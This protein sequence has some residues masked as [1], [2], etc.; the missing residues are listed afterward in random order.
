MKFKLLMLLLACGIVFNSSAQN[1]IKGKVTDE[2]GDGMPGVN[3]E[4]LQT[5]VKRATT[6]YNGN[7]SI[8]VASKNATITFKFIGYISQGIVINGRNT[9]DVK[10]KIDNT[11]LQEVVVMGALGIEQSSKSVAYATQSVN[12]D[13]M[14]ENRDL[15]IVNALE[16]Q[17]AGLQLTTMGQPG[18]SSRV[19][20]R[21]EGDVTGNNQPLWVVDGI[22]I[23]NEMGEDG[24]LDYG[25]GAASLNPDD[26]ESIEVIKGPG[27]AALYGQKAA[28]G[29]ILVTT[30][31]AKL[32]DKGFGINVSHNMQVYSITEY[33]EYQNVYGEGKAGRLV[34]SVSRLT[35]NDALNMGANSM[36]WGA[37][38]LGQPFN[39]YSGEPHGYYPQP[40]NVRS[41]Y[42]SSYTSISNISISKADPNSAFRASYTFSNGNDILD[43]QNLKNKHNFNLTASRKLNSRFS[44]DVSLNYT[45]DDTKNRTERNLN[46]GSPMAAYVYMAR[47]T[48]VAAFTPWIDENEKSVQRGTV[49]SSENPYWSIYE[50]ENRDQKS[51]LIG[52]ATL[53][54]ELVKGLAFRGKINGDIDHTKLY[55][56]KDMGARIDTN[57]YYRRSN[58]DRTSWNYQALFSYNKKINKEFTLRVNIGGEINKKGYFRRNSV[59]EALY[60]RKKPTIYNATVSPSDS[61]EILASQINSLFAQSNFSYKNF[62]YLNIT[63]RSEWSSTLPVGT[64]LFYPS[65][66]TS[67]VFSDLMKIDKKILSSGKLRL[68]WAK[69]GNSPAPY[70]LVNGYT[71]TLFL[72]NP[73]LSYDSGKNNSELKPAQKTA[74]ELGLDLTFFKSRMNFSGTVYQDNTTNQLLRASVAYETGFTSRMLNAGEVRN[75]GVEMTLGVTAIKTKNLTWSFNANWSKNVNKVLSLY[76]GVDE[77]KLGGQVLGAYASAV[78]GMPYGVLRGRG[79]YMTAD[80]K[81]LVQS[82]GRIF[83]EDDLIIGSSRPDWLGSLQNTIRY[84][85][86]DVSALLNVKWGGLL[87]SA[88]WARGTS[89][90][91]TSYT[92]DP[93]FG[94]DAWFF[95][96]A[97]LGESTNESK[98]LINV[99]GVLV[100]YE[101]ADRPKGGHYPNS[102]YIKTNEAGENILDENG[103]YV[104]GDKNISWVDPELL[105]ND[106]VLNNVPAATFS[107]T[108]IRISTLTIGYTVPKATLN[109]LAKGHINS[110]RL[111]F[112]ARNPLVLYKKTPNGIDPNSA[113]STG[114]QQGIENGGSFPYRQLGFNLSLSF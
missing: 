62:L 48:D 91:N 107:A 86:F 73:I 90:G 54:V 99:N 40:D 1:V 113:N 14:T 98:G 61:E 33:P 42:Q 36:S 100:P 53:N 92:L 109:K 5:P 55:L 34:T 38:M 8:S 30:K 67:F 2:N 21:G 60:V 101:D 103:R 70:Q 20:L 22:P 23:E 68:S 58:Y 72:G 46:T 78:V 59:I 10:M 105:A 88:T 50:N 63:G 35:E 75:R 111:A 6:D 97:I 24:D 57:G 95:A 17:V 47:S 13:G 64:R 16:G 89:V 81:I 96:R 3:V 93:I 66:G 11:L 15:N 84:K 4:T 65:V 43:N 108:N 41:L 19:I 102:Y 39:T 85:G 28:N 106:M 31:R 76:E 49:S 104:A 44:I 25:N 37:P 27:G 79:P 80:N 112:V 51:R 71:P 77:R 110:A 74:K 87:Y 9:I 94:R 45:N 56:Y 29:V 69:A 32:G 83:K 114:N 7:Y 18:S 26:I 82:N 52:G 12:L